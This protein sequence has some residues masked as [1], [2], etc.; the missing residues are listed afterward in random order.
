[1]KRKIDWSYLFSLAASV[2][3]ALLVGAVI[4]LITGRDPVA[5]Y[6]ELVRGAT[7]CKSLGEFFTAAFT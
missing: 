6:T 2:V 1:M 7:G 5:A 4:M 3:F